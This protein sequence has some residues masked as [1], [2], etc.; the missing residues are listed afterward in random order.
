[1]SLRNAQRG[2]LLIIAVV[3]IVVVGFLA[4]VV[5]FLSVGQLSTGTDSGSSTEA[6]YLAESGLERGVRQWLQNPG[7]YLSEGPV[8][9]GSGTFTITVSATDAA[10]AALPANQRRIISVGQVAATGGMAAH[11][12]EAIVQLGGGGG[13]TEPFPDINNWLTAGPSG[14]RFYTGCSLSGSNTRSPLTQGT[15]SFDPA[16]NAPGSTGGAFRAEVVAGNNREQLGGYRE[17]TLPSPLA[18]GDNITLD[19]WY[20]KVRGRPTPGNMMMA[21][22]LVASNNTVYRPWS[23][24]ST[25][26]INWT[27]ASVAWTVPNG[28]TIDRIRLAYYIRNGRS[29]RGRVTASAVLFD[30][31][32]LT[33]PGGSGTTGVLSQQDVTP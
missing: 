31:I 23:D 26:N 5:A 8:T 7:T 11:T 3:M 4:S 24:C 22:D 14:D 1:M 12:T 30:Q 2:S 6:L 18:A 21:I 16:N 32:V 17:F 29:R 19:F 20:M 10:G 15:V 27:A 33:T 25:G 13:F 28:R 9:L